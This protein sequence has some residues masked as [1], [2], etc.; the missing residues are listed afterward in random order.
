MKRRTKA[1]RRLAAALGEVLADAKGEKALPVV[2]AVPRRV[3]VKAVRR[4]TGLSQAA[5]ARRFGVNPR[6]LQDWE[7][8]RY[9]PDSMARALLIIIDREPAAVARALGGADRA[10]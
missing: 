2:A 1:G 7:Q 10:A 4:K 5:F 6:T 8:G 9:A 3:N